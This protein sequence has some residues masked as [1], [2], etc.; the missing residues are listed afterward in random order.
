[1]NLCQKFCAALFDVQ[2]YCWSWANSAEEPPLDVQAEVAVEIPHPQRPGKVA[3]FGVPDHAASAAVAACPLLNDRA[4][5]LCAVAGIDAQVGDKVLDEEALS[6]GVNAGRT[7][8]RRTL[9][10]E[11]GAERRELVGLDGRRVGIDDNGVAGALLD[12][13]A[14][15]V[16]VTV[17]WS[18]LKTLVAPDVD[19]RDKDVGRGTVGVRGRFR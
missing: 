2:W 13:Q 9:I 19:Q 8:P 4:I 12:G 18:G 6:A 17:L 11:H 7:I 16:V 15:P 5:A 10:V 14:G 1:M 3:L